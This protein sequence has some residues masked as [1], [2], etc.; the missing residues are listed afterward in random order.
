M[1]H[2]KFSLTK[3][4]IKHSG[5]KHSLKTQIIVPLITVFVVSF[6]K[7][8]IEPYTLNKAPFL[9]FYIP[10][11]LSAWYGGFR[12]GV[13]AVLLSATVVNYLFLEPK[14]TF[15]TKDIPSILNLFLF[16]LQGIVWVYFIQI[17]NAAILNERIVNKKLKEREEKLIATKSQLQTLIDSAQEPI[18][19]K[20]S[21]CK[22]ILVNP[23][24]RKIYNKPLKKILGKDD[25][26]IFSKDIAENIIQTDKRVLQT[27]KTESL[28]EKWIVDHQ[29]RYYLITKSPLRNANGD[30]KG[31]IG[32]AKDITDRKELERK[33]DE[34]IGIASH[35]LKTPLTSVKG[36]VQL[37]DRMLK[38]TS[39]KT[40]SQYILKA[41]TYIDKLTALINDLLDV[42]KIQAGKMQLNYL[43]FDI[44]E[45]VNEGI[46]SIKPV[47]NNHKIIKRDII[48]TKIWA[49]KERL[50]QVLTNLLVNAIKYSPDSDV[51][52]ID[53]KNQN[54]H[55]QVGITDFG[56]G[57]SKHDQDLIFDRFYRVDKSVKTISGLGIGLY[58]CSEIIK[59]HNGKIW[60]ESKEGK[61]STFYFAIPHKLNRNSSIS[62]AN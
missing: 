38:T 18:Y 3:F 48:H 62:K 20:N 16:S 22:Y 28:E 12:G 51:V 33:K 23:S 58:I 29:E 54:G 46:E 5:R 7:F 10:V 26:S 49:D 60:V 1:I 52:Y 4:L 40:V 53:V 31:I 30:I 9:L 6:I 27:G 11:L 15:F 19:M 34:F 50:I 37:L 25:F 13:I 14:Y 59:R 2:N 55:I 24:A 43:Q 47:V 35:E 32:I 36:Y 57:I 45:L 21:K 44:D 61:G 39:N 41:N 56:V 8:S 42:S 17:M